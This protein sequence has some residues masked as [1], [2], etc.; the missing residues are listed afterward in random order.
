MG[1]FRGVLQKDDDDR[2]RPPKVI[3]VEPNAFA[4]EWE[5]RPLEPVAIGL[6]IIPDEDLQTARAE[7]AK[8]AQ[9]MHDDIGTQEAAD[10]FNDALLRWIIARSTCQPDDVRQ[11]FFEFAE[12]TVRVALST[13]G[14]KAI[15]FQL[16]VFKTETS[17]LLKPIDH[18]EELDLAHILTE[19]APWSAMSEAEARG[20]KR[21]LRVALERFGEAFASAESAAG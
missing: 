21:L 11:P 7:A 5:T 3:T 10:C 9:G 8:F 16:E 13:E 12:D 14:V 2:W 18:E 17:P 20:T 1:T 19:G 6:R 15:S 4:S